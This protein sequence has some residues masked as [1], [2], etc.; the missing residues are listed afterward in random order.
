VWC[1][2]VFVVWG[3]VG[4]VGGFGWSGGGGGGGVVLLGQ[5]EMGEWVGG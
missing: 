2:G 3:W 1:V 4:G 5:V